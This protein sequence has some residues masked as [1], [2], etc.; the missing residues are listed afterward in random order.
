MGK[1]RQTQSEL[2]AQLCDQTDLLMLHCA[3]FDEG[4]HV[5][6]KPMATTLRVLLH[7]NP[8]PRSNSRALLDQLGLRTGRWRNV[9]QS[10]HPCEHKI[11][12]TVIGFYISMVVGGADRSACCTP[13]LKGLDDGLR[14]TPFAAWWTEPVAYNSDSGK[15]FSRMDIVRHVADTDGGAHVDS[16]LDDSYAAF[17]SGDFL[18]VRAAWR[19]GS[20]G[21]SLSREQGTPIPGAAWAAVRTIA[22]ETLIS[23]QEKA[24]KGFRRPYEWNAPRSPS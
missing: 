20:V 15:V 21:I 9:A 17:R 19:P 12:C 6:A 8:N 13:I 16:A 2:W 4:K 18:S 10:G 11:P 5:V 23:L 3:N 24:K 1:Q 22:H 7:S 14:R